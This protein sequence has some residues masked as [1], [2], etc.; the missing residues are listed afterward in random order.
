MVA[1]LLFPNRS[2]RRHRL[3]LRTQRPFASI[4]APNSSTRDRRGHWPS[5]DEIPDSKQR[6]VDIEPQRTPFPMD[7]TGRETAGGCFRHTEQRVGSRRANG[8]L[9]SKRNQSYEGV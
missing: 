9:E 5:A 8:L 4:M 2:R 6:L 3:L 1:R 7:A